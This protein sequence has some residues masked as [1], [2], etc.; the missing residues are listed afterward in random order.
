LN[1]YTESNT[2]AIRL[3]DPQSASEAV[4]VLIPESK[5][6]SFIVRHL[7]LWIL[8]TSAEAFRNLL[9]VFKGDNIVIEK[10]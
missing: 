3:N 7:Y 6:H 10:G 1:K 8:L 9:R 2:A 4:S 5:R